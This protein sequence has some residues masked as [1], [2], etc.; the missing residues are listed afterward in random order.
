MWTLINYSITVC[1]LN[2]RITLNIAKMV[3][4]PYLVISLYPLIEIPM[5]R[6]KIDHQKP[7]KSFNDTIQ[8]NVNFLEEI[9]LTQMCF[10]KIGKTI[11]THEIKTIHQKKNDS[12]FL[13]IHAFT[14]I[15]HIR[16]PSY[17]QPDS[18][19]CSK[20]TDFLDA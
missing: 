2:V 11:Q 13:A 19:S 10:G 1:L 3:R 12:K 4:F 14:S 16:S 7:M 15:F 5:K 6:Q 20:G 9:F 17:K 18:L 8:I